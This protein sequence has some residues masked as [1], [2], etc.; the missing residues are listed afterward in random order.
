MPCPDTIQ[1]MP[2]LTFKFRCF[3]VYRYHVCSLASFRHSSP[4]LHPRM[5]VIS[6]TDL[7]YLH[8]ERALTCR[9]QTPPIACGRMVSRWM[10]PLAVIAPICSSIDSKRYFQTAANIRSNGDMFTRLGSCDELSVNIMVRPSSIACSAFRKAQ[11]WIWQKQN[12]SRSIIYCYSGFLE[13]SFFLWRA[14]S[15]RIAIR[16][17]QISERC[18]SRRQRTWFR[19]S[20]RHAESSVH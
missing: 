6:L 10:I 13:L 2:D 14:V 1:S 19:S 5:L 11:K 17:L 16:Y 20:C 3:T 9:S 7:H 4:L 15:S 8:H 18:R 12:I